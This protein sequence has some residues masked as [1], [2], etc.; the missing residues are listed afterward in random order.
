MVTCES[1][2]NIL[3]SITSTDVHVMA[4]H[5]SSH[6][7]F[8]KPVLVGSEFGWTRDSMIQFL[9]VVLLNWNLF[10]SILSW[11]SNPN[12]PFPEIGSDVPD[13]ADPGANGPVHYERSSAGS[14]LL[15]LP[16]FLLVYM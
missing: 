16:V 15:P 2:I 10:A 13:T 12:L 11:D 4:V 5:P 1:L 6:L 9:F 3:R 8:S 14:R 7:G